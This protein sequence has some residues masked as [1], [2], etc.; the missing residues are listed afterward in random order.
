VKPVGKTV[1]IF[2]CRDENQSKEY[3][4][5][6]KRAK[7]TITGISGD[8]CSMLKNTSNSPKKAGNGGTGI[9][10]RKVTRRKVIKSGLIVLTPRNKIISRV[11][12]IKLVCPTPKKSKG[13]EIP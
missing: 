12:K 1:A 9:T 6:S 10:R 7:N 4:R 11:L 8:N 13:E 3:K 2:P 5:P